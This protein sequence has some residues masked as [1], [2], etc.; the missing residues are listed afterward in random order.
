MHRSRHTA[1]CMSKCLKLLIVSYGLS[2][3]I[4]LVRIC[5]M[6]VCYNHGKSNM[7]I[8]VCV[9]CVYACMCMCEYVCGCVHVCVCVCVRVYYMCVHVR[10]YV[11]ICL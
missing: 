1:D 3:H 8:G 5:F 7:Y 10:V 11:Y 2:E 6:T 9:V 4:S